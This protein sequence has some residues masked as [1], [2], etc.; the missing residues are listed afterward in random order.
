MCTH[1]P[2][3]LGFIHY[4]QHP[5]RVQIEVLV[6]HKERRRRVFYHLIFIQL[7]N[8]VEWL[9]LWLFLKV[10]HIDFF[11]IKKNEQT[12]VSA[13]PVFPFQS[14][15]SH[16]MRRN[17]AIDF[18]SCH[19][20]SV[21]NIL[22]YCTSAD[23]PAVHSQCLRGIHVASLNRTFRGRIRQVLKFRNQGSFSLRRSPNP[24]KDSIQEKK[25]CWQIL[26]QSSDFAVSAKA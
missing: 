23:I 11:H 16:T 18:S 6:W 13:S 26:G 19:V 10:Q 7:W 3:P 15:A 24:S 22:I 20:M 1:Q 21:Y 17:D 2:P 14:L 4:D 12:P 5:P 8:L 25:K 9:W